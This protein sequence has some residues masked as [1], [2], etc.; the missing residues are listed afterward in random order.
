MLPVRPWRHPLSV[1]GII[2]W[3]MV[4]WFHS[5]NQSDELSLEVGIFVESTVY[6]KSINIQILGKSVDVAVSWPLL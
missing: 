2:R 5:R 3:L 6:D 1:N 4:E